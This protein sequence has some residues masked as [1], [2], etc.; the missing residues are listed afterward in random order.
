MLP[1][2]APELGDRARGWAL[3]SR[4][5]SY[6]E[7]RAVESGWPGLP[8]GLSENLGPRGGPSLRWRLGPRPRGVVPGCVLETASTRRV[9]APLRK[10]TGPLL[11]L[12][13]TEHMPFS[14]RLEPGTGADSSLSLRL[15]PGPWEGSQ[16]VL[17]QRK[18]APAHSE[19]RESI[20]QEAGPA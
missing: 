5:A 10:D 11:Q 14:V 2:G 8:R 16:P 15:C 4:E 19:T 7:E 1:C 17:G 3:R 12:V 13:W 18:T 20:G 6:E 9:E